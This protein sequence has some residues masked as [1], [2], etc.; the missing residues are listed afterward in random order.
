MEASKYQKRI[1]WLQYCLAKYEN[2]LI[3]TVNCLYT[4]KDLLNFHNESYR[5]DFQ[6]QRQ[7]NRIDMETVEKLIVTLERT[8]SLND[9]PRLYEGR[10][11]DVLIDVLKMN[12]I[13]LVDSSASDESN[14]RITTQIEVLLECFWSLDMF[15]E[16]FIWAERCLAY[17]LDYFMNAAKDSVKQTEWAK[18]TSFVLTYIESL[19]I[20]ETNSIGR[21]PGKK[22]LKKLI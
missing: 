20:N 1:Y 8:I 22:F 21:F 5:L 19:F 16:C 2:D 18:N 9:V 13:N 15:E 6:N 11:F 17:S 12:L 10:N 14:I 3:R 7:H 4:I